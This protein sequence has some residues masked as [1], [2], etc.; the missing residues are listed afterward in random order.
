[1]PSLTAYLLG[2]RLYPADEASRLRWCRIPRGP[3]LDVS[4][5]RSRSLPQ[6]RMSRKLVASVTEAM[7]DGPDGIADADD[8]WTMTTLSLAGGVAQV[9]PMSPLERRFYGDGPIVAMRRSTRFEAMDSG[10]YTR[11]LD[12]A[13]SFL[14]LPQW[15][16]LADS[17]PGRDAMNI[18][19][20]MRAEP[21]MIGDGR[22]AGRARPA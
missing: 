20:K 22:R 9:R 16:W 13:A 2:D 17:R 4:I 11:W 6:H 1:M 21:P 10:E 18:L 8:E 12:G 15:G 5:V 3:E 19:A 14:M 7:R